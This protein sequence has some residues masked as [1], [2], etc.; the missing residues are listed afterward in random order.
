MTSSAFCCCSGIN[1]Q[2][3]I[4]DHTGKAKKIASA[5]KL[6]QE[7]QRYNDSYRTMQIDCQVALEI[8]AEDNLRDVRAFNATLT[9][10][11]P[12]EF[13]LSFVSEI[14]EKMV[15]LFYRNGKAIILFV[16]KSLR[17]TSVLPGIISSVANDIR[18]VF[19][20]EPKLVPDRV[21]MEETVSFAS[22]S[23]PLFDLKQ[24]K[25]DLLV[26]QTTVFAASLT[27]SRNDWF[28]EK[29]TTRT[30]VFGDYHRHGTVPVPHSVIVSTRGKTEYWFSVNVRSVQ[31]NVELKKG[32]FN[33]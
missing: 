27:I 6:I 9:I 4:I 28:D 22:G 1:I 11:K 31:V 15:E 29:G 13:H 16:A 32:W 18:A 21:E 14:G 3:T 33:Q 7:I 12:G 19:R 20:L 10:Q 26:L 23:A 30:I 17:E 24:Y 5:K 2:P 8:V 25:D